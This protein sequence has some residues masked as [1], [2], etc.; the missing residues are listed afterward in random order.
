[1]HLRVLIKTINTNSFGAAMLVTKKQIL[2]YYIL[3]WCLHP[4]EPLP[5][6]LDH[7]PAWNNTPPPPPPPKK[8]YIYMYIIAQFTSSHPPGNA[9]TWPLKGSELSGCSWMHRYYIYKKYF[10]N[11]FLTLSLYQKIVVNNSIIIKIKCMYWFYYKIVIDSPQRKN[12]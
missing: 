12:K 9:G 1:M 7:I 5:L 3:P 8:K 10:E 2:K 11:K 4:F 6:P